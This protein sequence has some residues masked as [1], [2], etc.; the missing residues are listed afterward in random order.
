M[1]NF[2][3]NNIDSCFL[4]LINAV[5]KFKQVYFALKFYFYL[6]TCESIYTK[7]NGKQDCQTSLIQINA[8]YFKDFNE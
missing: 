6:I 7:G 5:K 2:K 1:L 3:V 8:D 4:Y